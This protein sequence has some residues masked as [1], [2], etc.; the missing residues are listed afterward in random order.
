[1]KSRDGSGT[2]ETVDDPSGT[3]GV[4]AMVIEI[5]FKRA[6]GEVAPVGPSQY[7]PL[8]ED[9]GRDFGFEREIRLFQERQVHKITHTLVIFKPG[10][11]DISPAVIDLIRP[12]VGQSAILYFPSVGFSVTFTPLLYWLHG[13]AGLVIRCGQH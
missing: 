7:H 13:F 6:S 9:L 4:V 2:I 3:E 10:E 8:N 1:M 11:L 12:G 5:V